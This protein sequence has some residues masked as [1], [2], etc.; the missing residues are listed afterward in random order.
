VTAA[1]LRELEKRLKSEPGNIGL[2]VAVA[3]ALHE[4]GRHVEAVELYR[5]VAVAY[6]D[7]GRTQQAIA[8][9]RSILEIAPGDVPCQQLLAAL[10]PPPRRS[11]FDETPLPGALPYHVADPTTRSLPKLSELEIKPRASEPDGSFTL[12]ELK[13]IPTAE[14]SSTHAAPKRP[15]PPPPPRAIPHDVATELETRKRPRIEASDLRKIAALDADEDAPTKPPVD[16]ADTE[17]EVTVP[18]DDF[19][20]KR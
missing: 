20:F 10:Q 13:A 6:R 2:R 9:C 4:A 7:Q 5:S 18:R 15:P 14:G 17:E 19:D 16:P 1:A 8:V 11:S 3:G 12:P